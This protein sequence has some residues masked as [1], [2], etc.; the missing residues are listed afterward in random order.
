MAGWRY[1]S[2]MSG[3]VGSDARQSA[4]QRPKAV[5]T[6]RTRKKARYPCCVDYHGISPESEI[7]IPKGYE[8]LACAEQEAVVRPAELHFC[9]VV[10]MRTPSGLPDSETVVQLAI[11]NYNLPDPIQL[12]GW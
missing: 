10:L 11:I 6:K 7:F 9:S 4:G 1:Q 3:G 5:I 12:A 8:R 2:S